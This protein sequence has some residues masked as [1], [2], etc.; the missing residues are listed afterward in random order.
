MNVLQERKIEYKLKF[1]P[2]RHKSFNRPEFS[3]S[4]KKKEDLKNKQ[5]QKR[6]SS[7]MQFASKNN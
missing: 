5:R 6:L 3:S 7:I 4:L 2:K 1:E